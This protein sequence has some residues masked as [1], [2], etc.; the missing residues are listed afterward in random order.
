[1]KTT[2]KLHRSVLEK[3]ERLPQ[4][5]KK[6]VEKI[7]SYAIERLS[8]NQPHFTEEELFE[9]SDEIIGKVTEKKLFWKERQLKEKEKE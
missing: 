3:F 9:F 1:M 4:Q 6:N 7:I 8:S 5:D 2:L